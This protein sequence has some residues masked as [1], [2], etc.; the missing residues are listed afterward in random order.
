M[1]E[2][3]L[4]DVEV[5]MNCI[6]EMMQNICKDLPPY[7][8]SMIEKRYEEFRHAILRSMLDKHGGVEKVA[9]LLRDAIANIE[10]ETKNEIH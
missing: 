6:P 1:I 5:L 3:D 8:H 9:V 2:K 7:F 10:K 4:L